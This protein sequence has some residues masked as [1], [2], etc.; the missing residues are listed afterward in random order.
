VVWTGDF[1]RTPKLNARGGRDHWGGCASVFL[2]GAGIRGGQVLGSSD[3]AAAY[4]KDHPVR[5]GDV[6]ATVY[7]CLGVDPRRTLPGPLGRPLPICAGEPIRPL[8]T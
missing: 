1:G 5:P 7:H 3:R 4:P 8:L 6:V 2:A